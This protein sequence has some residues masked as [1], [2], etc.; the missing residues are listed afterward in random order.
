M[1]GERPWALISI[2][3]LVILCAVSYYAHLAQLLAA[4]E[5]LPAAISL[6]GIWVLLLAGIRAVSPSTY[7]MSPFGTAAWGILILTL[8]SLWFLSVRG[9]PMENM[10]VVAGLMLGLLIVVI[11]L[12]ER[13]GW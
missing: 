5:V 12:R 3:V 6:A 9:F 7:A 10:V 2:G 4:G 11:G 1:A 13:G 8:G